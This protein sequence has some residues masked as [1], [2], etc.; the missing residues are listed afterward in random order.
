M[1]HCLT[2]FEPSPLNAEMLTLIIMKGY[3][4]Q[5]HEFPCIT[6]WLVGIA[7]PEIVLSISKT[8]LWHITTY[9]TADVLEHTR[10]LA[11]G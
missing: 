5:S 4:L 8:F 11:K 2:N 3:E 1:L 6:G 9:F 7:I 10:R